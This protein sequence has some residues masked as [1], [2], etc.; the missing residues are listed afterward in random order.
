LR[1]AALDYALRLALSVSDVAPDEF[2][3]QRERGVHNGEGARARVNDEISRPAGRA[4]E[5]TDEA[6]GFDVRMQI[7]IDL[8]DPPIGDRVIGPSGFCGDGGLL[9]YDKV[10]AATSGAV[11]HPDALI[12]PGN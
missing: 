1:Q 4:N 7:A 9:E 12:I 6:N 10:V 2:P 8:L 3:A 5:S 11:P